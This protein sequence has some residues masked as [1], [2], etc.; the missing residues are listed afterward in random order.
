MAYKSAADFVNHLNEDWKKDYEKSLKDYDDKTEE[1]KERIGYNEMSD[2]EK[3]KFDADR[4][5]GREKMTGEY[6]ANQAKEKRDA[7]DADEENDNDQSQGK[8]NQEIEHSTKKETQ[9]QEYEIG[10]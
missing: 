3:E 9:D 2:D 5:T 8:D 6:Y 1:L 7:T 10:W 4:N